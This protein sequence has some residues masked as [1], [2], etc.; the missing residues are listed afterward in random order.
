MQS[1]V[2][3]ARL[4]PATRSAGS[5]TKVE[6][7]TREKKKSEKGEKKRRRRSRRGKEGGKKKQTTQQVL[8]K[9]SKN[10]TPRGGNSPAD[11][12][13]VLAS[14]LRRCSGTV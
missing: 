11:S 7:G 4:P 1:R 8:S 6:S 3:K 5:G 12:L 2:P 14:Q 9:P 10:L 13:A